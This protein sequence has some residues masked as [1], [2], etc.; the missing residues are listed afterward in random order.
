MLK[1]PS[2]GK[3]SKF[4]EYPANPIVFVDIPDQDMSSALSIQRMNRGFHSQAFY[5]APSTQS[6]MLNIEMGQTNSPTNI[7]S[8]LHPSSAQILQSFYN[9]NS[10]LSHK[11]ILAANDNVVVYQTEND[12]LMQKLRNPMAKVEYVPIPQTQYF[13]FPPSQNNLE[14]FHRNNSFLLRPNPVNQSLKNAYM[15][16]EWVKQQWRT[17]NFEL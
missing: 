15:I 11:P 3:P 2:K 7:L 10:S 9:P 17:N 16:N 12:T 5:Q 13:P 8:L 4:T 1:K 6:R 14:Y